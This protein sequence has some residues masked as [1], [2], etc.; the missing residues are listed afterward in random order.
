MAKA[1]G[2]VAVLSKSQ[3]T[4]FLA[5][6]EEELPFAEPV[7]DFQHSRNAALVCFILDGRRRKMANVNVQSAPSEILPTEERTA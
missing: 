2:F 5:W 1:S 7:A 4:A 6:V 3:M